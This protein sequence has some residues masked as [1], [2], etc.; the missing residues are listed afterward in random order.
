MVTLKTLL[1]VLV[2]GLVAWM[3]QPSHAEPVAPVS[4][5]E[6]LTKFPWDQSDA[7]YFLSDCQGSSEHQEKTLSE[8]IRRLQITT[9]S[10]ERRD[11]NGLL[12]TISY[13]IAASRKAEHIT[14]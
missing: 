10:D 4:F 9:D 12:N 13:Q 3:L 11:T 14:K 8:A 7:S 5:E 6:R 2:V 1:A